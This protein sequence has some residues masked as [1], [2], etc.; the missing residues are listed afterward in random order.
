MLFR[1]EEGSGTRAVTLDYLKQNGCPLDRLQNYPVFGST[2]SSLSA[3]E[4]GLGI[5][6]LSESAIKDALKLG[7]I[8]VLS[9]AY[10]IP[11]PLYFI[12]YKK[13]KL[14]PSA[15]AFKRFVTL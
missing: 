2:K 14:S 8:R 6:W 12:Q 10:D 5:G 15:A 7:H 9:D 11:R 3:I 13:R 4:S 1:S